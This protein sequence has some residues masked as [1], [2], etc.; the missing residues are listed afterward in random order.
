MKRFFL[1]LISV[2]STAVALAF[3]DYFFGI[4]KGEWI[5]TLLLGLALIAAMDFSLAVGDL[6]NGVRQ[7]IA[8]RGKTREEWDSEFSDPEI[9]AMWN[10]SH[11]FIS[12]G[13]ETPKGLISERRG[14]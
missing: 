3:T 6:L 4:L 10:R 11:Y 5:Y 12:R 9:E 13:M 1:I 8:V 2:A 14:E 7:E